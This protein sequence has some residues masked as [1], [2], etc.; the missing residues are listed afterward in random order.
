MSSLGE[1]AQIK[2]VRYLL[3]A[4]LRTFMQMVLDHVFVS[5]TSPAFFSLSMAH[6]GSHNLIQQ[7]YASG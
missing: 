6:K 4:D 2:S 5:F 3:S 7:C 1:A